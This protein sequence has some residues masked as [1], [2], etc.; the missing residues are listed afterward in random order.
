M[1]KKYELEDKRLLQVV[2]NTVAITSKMKSIVVDNSAKVGSIINLVSKNKN[3][4][5]KK[6]EFLSLKEDIFH[7]P[8]STKDQEVEFNNESPVTGDQIEEDQ[9]IVDPE[10]I[11]RNLKTN[12]IE[13]REKLFVDKS[14]RKQLGV[15]MEEKSHANPNFSVLNRANTKGYFSNDMINM[16]RNINQT[17]T[18][19]RKRLDS[20]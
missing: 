6:Y 10:T 7:S 12:R 15:T 14:I 2:F 17:Y 3:L 11:V 5:L 8:Y 18:G 13:L 16:A 4:N 9:R 20:D 19:D 1:R